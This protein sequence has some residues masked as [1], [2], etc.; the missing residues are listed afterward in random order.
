MHEGSW[1]PSGAGGAAAARIEWRSVRV[2]VSEQGGRC[3]QRYQVLRVLEQQATGV[4]RCEGGVT[5]CQKL[6]SIITCTTLQ[7]SRESEDPRVP[8]AYSGSRTWRLQPTR[9]HMQRR[10][11]PS[12]SPSDE[13]TS[14]AVE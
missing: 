12:M 3:A 2:Q 10:H 13:A 8:R 5:F 6:C 14:R 11:G 1:A 4:F 9:L 7:S